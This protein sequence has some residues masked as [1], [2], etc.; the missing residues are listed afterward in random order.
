MAAEKE[1]MA[2]DAGFWDVRLMNRK[3]S[4]A[5]IHGVGCAVR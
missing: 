2:A 5:G 1:R 4:L 3:N